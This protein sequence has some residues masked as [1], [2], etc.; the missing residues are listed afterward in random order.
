MSAS[1]QSWRVSGIA[2][3]LFV[4]LSFIAAAMNVQPPAHDQDASVVATWF[5]DNAQRYRTGH[6][7]AGL[8]FLVFYFPFFAG[9]C[10]RLRHAE[11]SPAIWSRVAWAGAIISPAA[12]TASGAFI[13]G[14]ALLE[15]DVSPEAALFATAANFYAYVVSGAFGGVVA[16]AAALVILRTGA[17]ARWL[18]WA[19]ALIGAAAIASTATLVE[20]DP[21]GLFAALNGLAWLA[22]FLW[23]AAISVGLL[24]S[25]RSR[26]IP[27]APRSPT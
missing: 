24:R 13:I 26:P 17:F 8:A 9:L 15:A 27:G 10:E 1:R 19:G 21:Q 12:G 20:N 7:V 4:A 14:A 16:L 22:Y 5:D 18:G 6:F 23:I 25:S 11:G 2:G 3:L